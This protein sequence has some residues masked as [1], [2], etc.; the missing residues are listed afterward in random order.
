MESTKKNFKQWL[1]DLDNKKVL[2]VTA[3]VLIW[4]FVAFSLLITILVFSA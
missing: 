1:K 4:A 2:S 3:N